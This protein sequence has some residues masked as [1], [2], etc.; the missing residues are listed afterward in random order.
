MCL[1]HSPFV[2]KKYEHNLSCKLCAVKN[3]ANLTPIKI[4]YIS[5]NE[6]TSLHGH[7]QAGYFF[8][9]PFYSEHLSYNSSF[10]GFF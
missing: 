3:K 7:T 1:L 6:Y 4:V 2:H 8:I 10:F 9:Y 5:A